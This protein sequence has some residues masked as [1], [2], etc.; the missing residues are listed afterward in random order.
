M[1]NNDN[2][3][4]KFTGDPVAFDGAEGKRDPKTDKGRFDL[5]PTEV[6]YPLFSKADHDWLLDCH[7]ASILMSIADEKFIEAII[8]MTIYSYSEHMEN[9]AASSLEFWHGVWPM[10]QDLAIHFQKGAV[11]YGERNCQKGIPLWSFKDS[12][13]RH[14]TQVFEGKTDEPHAI[15]VIWNCWMAQ[16]T[17]MQEKEKD[18]E[19]R[20][21]ALERATESRVNSALGDNLKDAV[22]NL[23]EVRKKLKT[24]RHN[25]T[26][27]A[28]KYDVL[29]QSIEGLKNVI[30][31]LFSITEANG[32]PR[33]DQGEYIM[34]PDG[35]LPVS[36][37]GEEWHSTKQP[38]DVHIRSDRELPQDQR[39]KL[40][41]DLTAIIKSLKDSRKDLMLQEYKYMSDSMEYVNIHQSVADLK[42]II[43]GLQCVADHVDIPIVT[44]VQKPAWQDA[45]DKIIKD[46]TENA[47]KAGIPWPPK[48][49][50]IVPENK[51]SEGI[52]VVM[53]SDY[54]GSD[55]DYIVT[56]AGEKMSA[57]EWFG[58]Q[59]NHRRM[60]QWFSPNELLN[61]LIERVS[62]DQGFGQDYRAYSDLFHK[63]YCEF[64]AYVDRKPVDTDYH[65]VVVCRCPTGA[66][67]EELYNRLSVINQSEKIVK[68][69]FI[70]NF[71]DTM[72]KITQRYDAIKRGA[73]GPLE[74][75]K[76]ALHGGFGAHE[77][78][79][80]P[81]P[82]SWEQVEELKSERTVDTV[83]IQQI[84]SKLREEL[85]KAHDIFTDT[86]GKGVQVFFNHLRP[87]MNDMLAMW[88]SI[89]PMLLD[90]KTPEQ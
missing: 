74:I 17:V 14:A 66:L 56:A 85:E 6:Y 65:R 59:K 32:S 78:D 76:V 49:P 34:T 2:K 81:F 4:I 63:L 15:S 11:H 41:A 19:R 5:I 42:R 40:K 75:P 13:M 89:A 51:Q 28:A 7:P 48:E 33:C 16:W 26:N 9:Y 87:A 86:D 35:E 20:L 18:A 47:K 30:N 67:L 69:N 23:R 62:E 58:K 31:T 38:V 45:Y 29:S 60:L 72:A 57:V 46:M 8:K 25:C 22:T 50:D 52:K 64:L 90:E 68:Q 83:A 73:T 43:K 61:E 44:A 70:A 53:S 27:D 24:E 12:A 80:V 37:L 79:A 84:I 21:L 71:Q 10:L 88:N 36:H 1:P 39:E 77:R 54:G 55:I 3:N 82:K